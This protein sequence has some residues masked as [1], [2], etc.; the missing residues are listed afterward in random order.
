MNISHDDGISNE[1]QTVTE[2]ETQSFYINVVE[3]YKEDLS[4]E[5]WLL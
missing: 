3:D 1:S 4:H 5:E 2:I